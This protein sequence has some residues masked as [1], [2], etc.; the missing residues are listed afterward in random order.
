[1]SSSVTCQWQ[2]MRQK[3]SCKHADSQSTEMLS[4]LKTW[5]RH[6]IK[7]HCASESWGTECV[8]WSVRAKT[9]FSPRVSVF[10][11][12]TSCR[13]D[14]VV[15]VQTLRYTQQDYMCSSF[16][17]RR[18]QPPGHPLR[19]YESLCIGPSLS[20]ISRFVSTMALN[21]LICADVPL[22]NYSLTHSL[23]EY[24]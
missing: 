11:S 10:V 14:R 12:W 9:N 2:L 23:R 7:T 4:L 21:G 1:M 16:S 3:S 5:C 17:S 15:T 13:R 6:V 24:A 18:P 8:V 20:L 22:S 19:F